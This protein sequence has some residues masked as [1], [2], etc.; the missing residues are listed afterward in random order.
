[1]D[2]R[3]PPRVGGGAFL[4]LAALGAGGC[5][6]P[7]VHRFPLR[8]PMWVDDDQRPYH[9]DCTPDPKKPKHAVCTPTEYVSPFVWDGVDA[10][11]FRPIT[12]FFAV[13]PAREAP[14]VNAL[15][16]V[17][18]SSWFENRIGR[19]PMTPEE[20]AAGPCEDDELDPDAPDGSWVID[21]G[22][23]NGANPGF[24]IK[25]EKA[26]KYLLKADEK[27]HPERAT[28]A[29]AIAT[30]LY[31]AAG[32]WTGCDEVVHVRRS[33]LK[34]TPG[35]ES[36]DNTGVT[37][38]FGEPQLEKILNG[39]AKRG[40]RYRLV[41]SKWLIGKTI[42]PFR[43]EGVRHDDPNDVI[44]HE[45]RRELRG[46]R[47][48][49]AWLGHFDSREQ[50][51][52][53]TWINGSEKDPDASPGH[54]RHWII[55]LNDCFG[56]EWEW[57]EITRRLNF[58]YYFDGGEVAYDYVTLGIPRR[59]WEKVRRNPNGAIFGYFES[60][61]FEPENWKPGYQNPAFVRMTER[62]GAWMARIL[63][64]LGPEHI[65]R[66]V[67]VG[68]FTKPEHSAYLTQTLIV[69]QR[70][71]LRR[72]FSILSPLADLEVRGSSVCGVDL[73]RRTAVFPL[74]SFRY[75]ATVR[76]GEQLDQ[77][78]FAAVAP[79][80]DGGFCVPLPRIAKDGGA[81]DDS[82]SRYLVVDVYNGV[83]REP[84][85]VHLYDLGPTKGYRLVGL[86]R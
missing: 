56:S 3:K 22:K 28:G 44:P 16:E 79:S 10:M 65:E 46:Q 75:G 55:D 9:V 83:S 29:T 27:G 68:D 40:D 67:R 32:F 51:S 61:L 48:L 14:N 86:E 1:V 36:T 38:P 71:I 58:S 70:K 82:A 7:A 52:M 20:V 47:L 78:A 72:Y 80:G 12:R 33:L 69:R 26:G 30:R 23:D 35:L 11:V 18:D 8:D 54:L 43:Y 17:P 63:A 57:E 21:K 53:T 31:H 73:A 74:A 15:D 81:P 84:L 34:L 19:A 6:A 5:S 24:R 25:V 37:R 13:D 45:D 64:R 66:V 42:G 76:S 60:E 50:N 39:A 49:A 2:S 4:I 59:P 62:D 77:R 85:H 41:A